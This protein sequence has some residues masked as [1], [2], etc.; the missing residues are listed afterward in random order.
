MC[1][2]ELLVLTWTHSFLLFPIFLLCNH[3][4]SLKR[5]IASHNQ[6]TTQKVLW[7][8]WTTFYNQWP[9]QVLMESANRCLLRTECTIVACTDAHWY[10]PADPSWAQ[11]YST[12][13]D[14][15]ELV[16]KYIY[17]RHHRHT[18]PTNWFADQG[19]CLGRDISHWLNATRRR[20]VRRFLRKRCDSRENGL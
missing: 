2:I 19:N 3:P 8:K 12:V 7:W 1:I 13:S 6:P 18:N 16:S 20:T 10:P 11:T 14:Q 5:R 15:K 4:S 17:G 9:A